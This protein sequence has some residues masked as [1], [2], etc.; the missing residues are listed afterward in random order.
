MFLLIPCKKSPHITPCHAKPT[1]YEFMHAPCIFAS[2]PQPHC[3]PFAYKRSFY[4][5]QSCPLK[6]KKWSHFDLKS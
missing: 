6:E 3:Q 1:M 4:G 2:L 5:H